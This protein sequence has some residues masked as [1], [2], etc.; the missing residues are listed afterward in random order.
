MDTQLCEWC[1]ESYICK[2]RDSYRKHSSYK[3]WL[4]KRYCSNRCYVQHKFWRK[5]TGEQSLSRLPSRDH[6][7]PRK[8]KLDPTVKVIP[9]W[10]KKPPPLR[11]MV[12]KHLSHNTSKTISELYECILNDYGTVT[13]RT[14]NRWLV[15]LQH[16]KKIKRHA[17]YNTDKDTTYTLNTPDSQATRLGSKSSRDDGTP[18]DC[19]AEW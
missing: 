5:K 3:Y 13:R 1:S 9:P 15:I 19:Y 8:L 6:H 11:L 14:V 4:L 2:N 18:D 16:E 12:L 7:V 10:E 17:L